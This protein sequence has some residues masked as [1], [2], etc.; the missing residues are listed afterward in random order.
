MGQFVE[1]YP[2]YEKR[3]KYAVTQKRFTMWMKAWGEHNGWEVVDGRDSMGGRYTL[4]DTD[5]VVSKEEKD[6]D[7][8]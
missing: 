2:D 1:E 6:E 4:Y 3:G 8:F 5:A 7:P